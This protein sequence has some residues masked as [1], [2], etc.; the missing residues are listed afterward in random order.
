MLHN[1]PQIH[2]KL[3]QA[4]IKATMGNIF[5][6]LKVFC[7]SVEYLLNLVFDDILT[8]YDLML[9]NYIEPYNAIKT[10]IC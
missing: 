8:T 2:L 4:V 3:S 1:I 5:D 9:V 10:F 6:D 7:R